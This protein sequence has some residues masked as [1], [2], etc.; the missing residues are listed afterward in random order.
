[1]ISNSLTILNLTTVLSCVYSVKHTLITLTGQPKVSIN[2]T[3]IHK[4]LLPNMMDI[5]FISKFISDSINAAAKEYIAPK[6]M[7]LDLQQLLSGDGINRGRW[8]F[9][10]LSVLDGRMTAMLTISIL[11]TVHIG[12]IVVHVHKVMI[13]RNTETDSTFT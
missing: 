13:E 5:P 11:D 8:R 3:P 6:S 9:I 1:M 10:N 7:M 12:V 2:I 4:K